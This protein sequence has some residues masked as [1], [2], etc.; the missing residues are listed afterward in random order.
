VDTSLRAEKI[1]Q[2][3]PAWTVA[4]R[5]QPLGSAGCVLD[6]VPVP[7]LVLFVPLPLPELVLL[8]PLPLPELVLLV[9]L[10]LPVF[11]QVPAEVVSCRL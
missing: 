9:P 4:L 1:S 7:E 5:V 3:S 11:E 2:V 10:P 6:C 8:V